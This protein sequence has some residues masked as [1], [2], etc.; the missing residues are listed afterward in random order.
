MIRLVYRLLVGLHPADFRERHGDE[1]LCIFDECAPGEARHLLADGLVSLLRQW[2]FHSRAWK[3]LAG[4]AVSTLLI[5]GWALSVT[6]GLDWSINWAAKRH[7]ELLAMYP[8][9]PDHPLDELEFE[10][11]AQEAVRMLAH[12]RQDAED[13]RRAHRRP[14]TSGPGVP[15]SPDSENRE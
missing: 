4:G 2:A 9:P 7:G 6:R 5:L 11:E 13:R 14:H 8:A 1:M 10:R 12:Y 3:F 15:S